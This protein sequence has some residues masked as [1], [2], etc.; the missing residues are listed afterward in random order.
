M[1]KSR[2]GVDDALTNNLI[3]IMDIIASKYLGRE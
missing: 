2:D 1:L 3:R